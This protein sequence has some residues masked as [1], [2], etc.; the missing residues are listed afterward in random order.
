MVI[1][2]DE[3]EQCRTSEQLKHF[4]ADV[5]ERV[6]SDPEQMQRA[7]R[8]E[9]VYRQFVNEIIPLSQFS[10]L[11]YDE[12]TKF[13]PVLGNQG[14]DVEVFD[15]KGRRIDH[16]EIAKPHDGYTEAKDN[17][18]LEDHGIG[19]IRAY[20]Y[21]GQLDAIASWIDETVQKKSDKD[22]SDCTLVI[23]AAIDPPYEEES[24]EVK[25]RSEELVANLKKTSFN[26]KRVFLAI[27]A[28]DEC[29]EIGGLHVVAV[30]RPKRC[31]ASAGN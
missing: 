30:D 25:R 23:V 4:V 18:L 8:K 22:Y 3:I 9:G 12:N 21:G 2:S 11:L 10:H 28:L 6:E 7:L 1:S 15:R 20:K 17:K 24:P 16:I 5:R 14:F 27:P 29:F 26:A 13:K 31:R 19:K